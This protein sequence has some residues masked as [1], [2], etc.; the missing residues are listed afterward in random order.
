VP[1]GTL[2]TDTPS[3]HTFQTSLSFSSTLSIGMHQLNFRAADADGDVGVS[4]VL[5]LRAQSLIPTGSLVVTLDWDTESDLDLHVTVPNAADSTMPVIVWAKAPLAL[6]PVGSSDPAYTAAQVAAA[7]SLD[8][9]SNAGCVIDGLRQEDLI[10]PVAPAPPPPTG[11]YE[12]RVD[13][14]SMCGQGVAHWH[15]IAVVDDDV[16]HPAGEA[17]GQLTDLDASRPHVATSGILAFTFS[18]P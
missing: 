1:T 14:T 4:H 10:F 8:H 15:A 6:L 9:D 11:T 2:D 13:A 5:T 17:F 3:N 12:V 16:D 7:G 18:M